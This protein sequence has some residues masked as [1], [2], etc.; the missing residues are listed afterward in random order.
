VSGTPS[1]TPG[2]APSLREQGIVVVKAL[3][4]IS[5]KLQPLREKQA[6]GKRL[7]KREQAQ[8]ESL[9][10]EYRQ[11]EGELRLLMRPRTRDLADL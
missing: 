4:A 11:L 6:A 3:S 5:T 8:L 2:G 10:A 1:S 9:D 7:T